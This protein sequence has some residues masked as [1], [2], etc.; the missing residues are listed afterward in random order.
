MGVSG[1]GVLWPINNYALPEVH[2]SG[3]LGMVWANN[4]QLWSHGRRWYLLIEKGV[5]VNLLVGGL[6][7]FEY[8]GHCYTTVLERSDNSVI[9]RLGKDT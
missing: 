8:L 1:V 2:V 9:A 7:V 6:G 5:S 4:V 3:L